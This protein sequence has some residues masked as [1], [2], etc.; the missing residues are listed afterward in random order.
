MDACNRCSTI[1][2]IATETVR[3]DR[4][5]GFSAQLR[6][7]LDRFVFELQKESRRMG[8]D[9]PDPPPS[10]EMQINSANPAS[11]RVQAAGELQSALEG[12]DTLLAHGFPGHP[13]AMMH[14]QRQ[15][16][17]LLLH[18]LEQLTGGYTPSML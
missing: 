13:G 3:D 4:F 18:D 6:Q 9:E 11:L 10:A 8:V 15:T 5:E 14:R 17:S 7:T 12:Y 2:R 1:F 16:L